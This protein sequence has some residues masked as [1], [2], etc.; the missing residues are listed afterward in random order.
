VTD[1][2]AMRMRSRRSFLKAGVAALGGVS[3]FHWLR[4]RRDDDGVPWPLRRV[5][6]TNEQLARDYFST[7]RLASTFPES[8]AGLPRENGREGLSAGFDFRSWT[9]KLVS[10]VHPKRLELTLDDIRALPR[11]EMVTELHCIEGWSQVVH[12]TGA[13]LSAL[14][15]EAGADARYVGMETPDGGYYVGMDMAS[16]VHPQT[17]LC[18]E[19]NG[20]ELTLEHGAP[21]RLATP[22][23]YGIKN[24]KRIGTIHFTNTRPRDFWA[25]Q[26]YDWYAGL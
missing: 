12:W 7:S 26:G 3:S 10:S 24:I 14:V 18:Y 8:M 20:Q 13:R 4:T 5:L 22:V 19:M 17:L 16:A 11:V 9:L 2:K 6:E 1:E 21:L 25:E 23:K 15:G